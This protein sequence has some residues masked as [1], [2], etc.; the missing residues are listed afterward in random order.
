MLENPTLKLWAYKRGRGYISDLKKCSGKPIYNT[1]QFCHIFNI[2]RNFI[3]FNR[4]EKL[5]GDKTYI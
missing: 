1:I 3:W 5:N 4:K 2:Y